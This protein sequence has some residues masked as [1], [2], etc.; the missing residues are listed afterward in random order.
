MLSLKIADFG[1]SRDLHESD[2]YKSGDRQ[3]KLPVKW[4]APESLSKH[5]FDTR[6]DV[7]CTFMC[8]IIIITI[9]YSLWGKYSLSVVMLH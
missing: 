3:T 6:T 2:Y 9:G 4:M 1:L 8:C 5:I 7:V